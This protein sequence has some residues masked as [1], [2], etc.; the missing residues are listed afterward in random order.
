MRANRSEWAANEALA[1]TCRESPRAPAVRLL[2][3]AKRRR[4]AQRERVAR[5]I[6]CACLA[7][8]PAALFMA[9]TQ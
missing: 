4:Q 9:Y 8:I 7:L 3:V 2:Y 5:A 6:T 1:T